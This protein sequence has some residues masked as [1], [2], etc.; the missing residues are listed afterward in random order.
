MKI[1][2][3]TDGSK[4]AL[5]AVKYASKLVR[6]LSSTSSSITLISVH[7]DAGLRH[8]TRF[9][10]R[11]VVA[12]YLRELSEKELKPARKL[13]DAAGIKHDME[14]R[15]GHIAQE[16]VQCAKSG[17]FDLIVLGAKGRSAIGD[18]LLGSVAQTVLAIADRPVL[19]AR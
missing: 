4:P 16:I 13:L 10:G 6:Q 18:F 1:L 5:Q 9:V 17:K 19:L 15:S 3:A 7:D 11:D 14:V 12:D 2:V 8:A